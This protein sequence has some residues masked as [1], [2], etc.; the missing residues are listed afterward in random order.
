MTPSMSQPP[1]ASVARSSPTAAL[2]HRSFSAP[3]MHPSERT[4]WC[5]EMSG[6][7]IPSLRCKGTQHADLITPIARV[8]PVHLAVGTHDLKVCV[9][10]RV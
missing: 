5:Q 6:V 2:W 8:S 1:R 4:I 10:R 9:Q 7:R 3:V